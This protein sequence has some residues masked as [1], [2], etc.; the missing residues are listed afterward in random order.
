[1]NNVDYGLDLTHESDD[2]TFYVQGTKYDYDDT[3]CAF[4]SRGL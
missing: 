2:W 1:M 3:S 4:S